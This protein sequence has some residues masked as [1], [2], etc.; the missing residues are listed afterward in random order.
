MQTTHDQS[1][2]LPHVRNHYLMYHDPIFG[3]TYDI[4]LTQN[5]EVDTIVRYRDRLGIDGVAYHAISDLPSHHRP[6]ITQLISSYSD[7]RPA[8]P[9]SCT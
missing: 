9:E 7:R 1:L 5:W 3:D 4:W 2:D 6:T 8:E